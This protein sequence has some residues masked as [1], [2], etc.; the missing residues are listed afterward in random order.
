MGFQTKLFSLTESLLSG[1]LLLAFLEDGLVEDVALH[2]DEMVQTHEGEDEEGDDS[3]KSSELGDHVHECR[4]SSLDDLD[5][6][7]Q[8]EGHR[9]ER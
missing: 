5:R 2:D 3:R 7:F 6:L 1:G 9:S 8:L 4:V